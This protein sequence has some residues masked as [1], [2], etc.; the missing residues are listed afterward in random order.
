MT[1]TA[2]DL[3]TIT[4]TTWNLLLIYLA[5][6]P[7]KEITHPE[8][9]LHDRSLLSLYQFMRYGDALHINRTLTSAALNLFPF[10][11]D[12]IDDIIFTTPSFIICIPTL[13]L[14]LYTG[15]GL[16]NFNHVLITHDSL[17]RDNLS[18]WL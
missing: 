12:R 8:L 17:V 6:L 9:C 1:G 2:P 15:L 16:T 14:S 18:Y 10:H 4:N 7:P 5:C 13:H 11:S 3:P